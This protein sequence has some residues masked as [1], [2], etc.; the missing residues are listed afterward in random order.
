[1][2]R[3]ARPGVPRLPLHAATSLKREAFVD[4]LPQPRDVARRRVVAEVAGAKRVAQLTVRHPLEPFADPAHVVHA[5]AI[6]D[7]LLMAPA[8][9]EADMSAVDAQDE[10]LALEA[11]D[12]SAPRIHPPR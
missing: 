1:M 12:V 8:E 5:D 4:L 2:P 11:V 7:Q 6:V 3:P 10:R 9:A